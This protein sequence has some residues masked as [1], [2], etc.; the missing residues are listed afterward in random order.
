MRRR[1]ATSNEPRRMLHIE[2][3]DRFDFGNDLRLGV[4]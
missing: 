3:A 1:S 4:A 2:Y